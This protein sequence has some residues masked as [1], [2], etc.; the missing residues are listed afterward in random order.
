[1]HAMM[2]NNSHRAPLNLDQK[3]FLIKQNFVPRLLY[4]FQ[5]SG[6]TGGLLTAADRLIR[7]FVKRVLQLN[8]HAPNAVIYPAARYG[9]LGVMSL[10]I[11]L[12]YTFYRRLDLPNK[13]CD[14]TIRAVVASPRV[15]HRITWQEIFQQTSVVAYGSNDGRS[16]KRLW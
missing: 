9:G 8:I 14:S 16:P 4:G 13:E 11:G 6:F 15:D 3:L 1:M 2:P 7:S 10:R 12:P 5:N